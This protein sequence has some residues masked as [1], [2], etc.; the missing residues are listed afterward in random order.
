M[1]PKG[2]DG[3]NILVVSEYFT[4]GGLETHIHS[5]YMRLRKEHRFTFAIGLFQSALEFDSKDLY[6][7]FHFGPGSSIADF[8]EDVEELV[9]L[10][11][12]RH[13]DVIH[14]HP[15]F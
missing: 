2:E 11:R 10:V 12:D 13:I 3:V 7:G 14:A 5:Y 4:R 9:R 15:F 6:T 8:V 1:R